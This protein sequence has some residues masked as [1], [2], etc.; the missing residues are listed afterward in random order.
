MNYP[1]KLVLFSFLVFNA[2]FSWWHT[3]SFS[4]N[5]IDST[6][7]PNCVMIFSHYA[8]AL[9]A[10]VTHARHF[11]KKASLTLDIQKWWASNNLSAANYIDAYPFIDCI[12][13]GES[14]RRSDRFLHLSSSTH[15]LSRFFREGESRDPPSFTPA[16]CA[17]SLS[18]PLI[19]SFAAS[20]CRSLCLA[21]PQR[22]A[23]GRQQ[24][25]AEGTLS[26]KQQPWHHLKYHLCSSR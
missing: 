1:Q 24:V 25:S 22:A 10:P 21:N 7:P 3:L 12:N 9:F 19:G 14:G 26:T 20:C 11:P 17:L 6:L 5:M 13:A 23:F 18:Y 2:P 15:T 16:V 8:C 4:L